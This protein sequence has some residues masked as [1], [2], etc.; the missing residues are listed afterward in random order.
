MSTNTLFCLSGDQNTDKRT[1][2]IYLPYLGYD[3]EVSF[4]K[5][6]ETVCQDLGFEVVFL[7]LSQRPETKKI[8]NIFELP[9]TLSR[10]AKAILDN[11]HDG[12][13]AIDFH[14]IARRESEWN[15]SPEP[16]GEELE[17]ITAG[18]RWLSVGFQQILFSIQ[19]S[20]VVFWGGEYTNQMIL[21][22][23][24]NSNQVPVAYIE[25]GILPGSLFFDKKG[26]SANS[27]FVSKTT[28]DS[29]VSSSTPQVAKA[30]NFE[31]FVKHYK[32]GE[33]W[34]EQPERVDLAKLRQ[35][36]GVGPEQKIIF[37][38]SQVDG[39]TSNF[40]F[41][42]NFENNAAAFKWLCDRFRDNPKFF[43]LGKHHPKSKTKPSAY[44]RSLSENGVWMKDIAIH[45]CLALCDYVALV[46]STV[47]LEAM[48]YGKPTLALGK[49]FFTGR[50]ILY[51][52]GSLSEANNVIS[53][54]LATSEFAD[55]IQNFKICIDDLATKHLFA[56]KNEM[57]E[58][59]LR[60]PKI[61]G[62]ILCALAKDSHPR[63]AIKNL[64]ATLDFLTEGMTT[65]ERI[66]YENAVMP[67]WDNVSGRELIR[68][69]AQ[70]II[71]RL[72]RR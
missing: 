15:E 3:Y 62:E 69:L 60:S 35:K 11:D 9:W 34:W 30:F 40:L 19:P 48:I 36:L 59:G 41:S 14:A 63:V 53:N 64:S 25:R 17:Q 20:L 21:R 61:F 5:R 33:S 24:C 13:T 72:Y 7:G 43:I 47:A 68:V 4:F 58:I 8:L 55:R 54:W 65:H 67:S 29:D 44:E 42:P 37:F 51:E 26:L 50:K 31:A 66:H 56:F 32:K 16:N 2:V 23:Q 52:V 28:G 39:D 6:V 46:N 10:R 18:I 71:K 38:P 70:K 57:E 45:D 49:S 12:V 1:V 22:H 27:S